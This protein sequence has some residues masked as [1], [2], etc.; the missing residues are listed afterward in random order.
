MTHIRQGVT[1]LLAA[2]ALT[3]GGVGL[4]SAATTSANHPAHTPCATQQTQLNRAEAKLQWL[5]TKFAAQS[6]K[7][8]A[9]KQAVST[10]K[11]EV[12]AAATKANPH[13]AHRLAEIELHRAQIALHRAQIEKSKVAK[14][15][16]AQ[17]KRVAHDTAALNTCLAAV[18]TP[19][20]SATSTPS[21]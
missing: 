5:T 14:A 1:A 10:A 13:R 3:A 20:P 4:A 19:A 16:K 18:P 6:A 11:T 15:K 2:A 7:V 8:T 17:Q 9:D 21:A 12:K